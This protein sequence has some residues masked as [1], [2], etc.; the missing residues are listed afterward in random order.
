MEYSFCPNCGKK[1]GHKRAIGM[2]TL[3]GGIF[4]FGAST[5][6]IPLYPKR[7][8]VC[9][10][11]SSEQNEQAPP[12]ENLRKCPMCAEYIKSE[13]K[14]CRFCNAKLDALPVTEVV[15]EEE[16]EP[17]P[18]VGP[19]KSAFSKLIP[20]IDGNCCGMLKTNG[21]CKRCGTPHPDFT[22]VTK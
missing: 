16:P 2:G 21:Y 12:T 9:G 11:K 17:T 15:D 7:C 5:L 1:T 3:L 8:I 22:R 19:Y 20:C 13:A 6:A 10:R 18:M 4:T 14:I